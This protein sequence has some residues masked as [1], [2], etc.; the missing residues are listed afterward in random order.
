MH[1]TLLPLRFERR[2]RLLGSIVLGRVVVSGV[3]PPFAAKIL[4]AGLSRPDAPD[5]NR[6]FRGPAGFLSAMVAMILTCFRLRWHYVVDSRR[7]RQTWTVARARRRPIEGVS[8]P[9]QSPTPLC[10]H[11]LNSIRRA[12]GKRS[13][14]R[15]REMCIQLWNF[16]AT[17]LRWA[18][19]LS[20][21]FRGGNELTQM[22]LNVEQVRFGSAC[23][24]ALDVEAACGDLRNTGA[25]DST[26][27]WRMP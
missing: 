21:S 19:A 20:N 26:A 17:S 1:A 7:R 23:K 14:A 18:S 6:R 2:A 16:P 25:A 12:D 11:S 4:Q 15:R 9:G 5:S 24:L 22:Y 13:G 27:P 3:H 8:R 10:Q